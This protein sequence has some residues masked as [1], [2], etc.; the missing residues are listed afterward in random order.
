M[1]D[2]SLILEKIAELALREKW[3]PEEV[4]VA[5]AAGAGQI[6]RTH[7]D[8]SSQSECLASL[9]KVMTHHAAGHVRETLQ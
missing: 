4:A 2:S 7:C 9:L 5:F 8:D 6:I 3:R 1:T